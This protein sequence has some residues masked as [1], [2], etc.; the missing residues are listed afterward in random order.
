MRRCWWIPVM[1]L[2][3]GC[4]VETHFYVW[5]GT[6]AEMVLEIMP[7]YIKPEAAGP[8]H[9]YRSTN[10][11]AAWNDYQKSSST[12]EVVPQSDGTYRFVVPPGSGVYLGEGRNSHHSSLKSICWMGAPQRHCV[13]LDH[14]LGQPYVDP[15]GGF[16][17]IRLA[18]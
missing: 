12:D 3:A 13:A 9:L 2:F 10:R 6:A 18:R 15:M 4:T 14:T 5:N 11:P 1:L 16:E 8:F 7:S 17:I